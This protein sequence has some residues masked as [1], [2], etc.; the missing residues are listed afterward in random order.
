MASDEV[1]LAQLDAVQMCVEDLSTKVERLDDSVR[2][3]GQPGLS[4]QVALLDKRVERCEDFILEVQALRRWLS[5]G[6]LSLLG[7]LAWRVI[8]W[9]MS[10]AS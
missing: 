4:T 5:L 1:L 10:H 3:N 7:T 9:S 8:E 6:I 2:G